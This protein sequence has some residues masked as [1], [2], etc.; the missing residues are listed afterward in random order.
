VF[1]LVKQ[2]ISEKLVEAGLHDLGRLGE[3]KTQHLARTLT[4]MIL[5]VDRTQARN[6]LFELTFATGIPLIAVGA[7][8]ASYYPEVAKQLAIRLCVPKHA[9]VA[10]AVG[11]VMGNVTQRVH[12]TI[13]QPVRGTFRLFTRDGPRDFAELTQAIAH[14]NR[15]A[16]EEATALALD[17]G[18]AS[19]DTCVA[20]D[21]N[22]VTNDIDGDVFFEVRVTATERGRPATISR[23]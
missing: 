9:E 4:E 5:G 19:V 15:L 11:A 6:P 21:E 16:V 7:P 14:A 13:T 3:A 20:R 22:S 17:S 10:N 23:D 1:G 18:A 12:L 8:A 2:R